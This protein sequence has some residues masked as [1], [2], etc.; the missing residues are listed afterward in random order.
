MI[1]KLLFIMRF[2]LKEE[3][4]KISSHDKHAFKESRDRKIM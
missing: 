3:E 1:L 4:C 2:V